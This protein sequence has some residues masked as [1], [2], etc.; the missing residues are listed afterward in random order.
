MH[1][2]VCVHTST[3]KKEKIKEE[4]EADED[5]NNNNI[6]PDGETNILAAKDRQIWRQRWKDRLAA[7]SKTD[8]QFPPAVNVHGVLQLL[9]QSLASCSLPQ[10][11]TL[12]VVHLTSAT[13]TQTSFNCSH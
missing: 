6:L 2:A 10:K 13:I 11:L 1:V 7:G 4:R 8:L 9:L 3:Y 5:K 12:D